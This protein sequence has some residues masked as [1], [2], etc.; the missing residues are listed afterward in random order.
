MR[1]NKDLEREEETKSWKVFLNS[2]NG[3]AMPLAILIVLVTALL[4]GALFAYA[5]TDIKAVK[6]DETREKARYLARSGAEA[7]IKDW[8]NH[9]LNGKIAGSIDTVYLSKDSNGKEIFTLTQPATDMGR[10]NVTIIKEKDSSG[11]ETGSY[12]FEGTATVDGITQK[13]TA[14]SS[15]YKV[16]LDEKWYDASG[17]VI[18]DNTKIEP[19]TITNHP[20]FGNA[21]FNL[22]YHEFK[23]VVNCDRDLNM[24]NDDSKNKIGFVAQSIFY[25]GSVDATQRIDWWEFIKNFI[26]NIFH[27]DR[28]KLPTGVLANSAGVIVFNKE[29]T[30]TDIYIGDNKL[31]YGTVIIGVPESLGIK[32]KNKDGVYGKVYFKN[33]VK[34]RKIVYKWHDGWFFDYVYDVEIKNVATIPAGGYYFKHREVNGK[35]AGIDLAEWYTYRENYSSDDMIKIEA[36][37]INFKFPDINSTFKFYWK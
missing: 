36:D 15:P 12:I 22:L 2:N 17:N 3:W 10:M 35:E 5:M 1:I 26:L 4:S 25:N 14:I 23:G 6:S 34:I 7:A 21:S 37:D 29:L 9:P 30:L 20:W 11:K 24:Q 28:L 13:A 27:L 18:T 16:G 8:M 32:L 31:V 33:P 19:I